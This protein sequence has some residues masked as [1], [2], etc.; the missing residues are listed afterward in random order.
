M[1]P[2]LPAELNRRLATHQPAQ[3]T[4]EATWARDEMRFWD[5]GAY[6]GDKHHVGLDRVYPRQ[7]FLFDRLLSERPPKLIIEVG[8]GRAESV[9]AGLDIVGL[10]A[11][12]IGIDGVAYETFPHGSA[13]VRVLADLNAPRL[14]LHSASADW[15]I[16]VETIEHLENP[17]AFCRELTRVVRPGGCLALTT[18]NQLSLASKLH[19]LL[20][21]E[22]VAFQEA[23]GLYPTHLTALLECDLRRLAAECGWDDVQI[24]YSGEGRVPGMARHYPAWCSRWWPRACSD[25]ILLFARRPA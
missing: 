3:T 1:T 4:P 7:K 10:G 8:C 20:F 16:A 22:F 21:Q 19:L 2:R 6:L 23:P 15:V 12:Y 13:V 25:N 17:R 24:V 11:T 18:P 14:P 9:A 5:E